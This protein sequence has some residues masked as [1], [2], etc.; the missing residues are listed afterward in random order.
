MCP[1]TGQPG[2]NGQIPRHT[3]LEDQEGTQNLNKEIHT[4]EIKSVIKV[5]PTKTSWTGLFHM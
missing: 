4:Y 2:R 1:Q 3:I 5:L